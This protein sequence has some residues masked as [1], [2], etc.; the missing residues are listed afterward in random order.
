MCL[1]ERCVRNR[2]WPVRQKKTT[3]TIAAAT[4]T[5]PLLL[6]STGKTNTISSGMLS[7]CLDAPSRTV[8]CDT[9]KDPGPQFPH[10]WVRSWC[11]CKLECLSTIP[12]HWTHLFSADPCCSPRRQRVCSDWS[13]CRTGRTPVGRHMLPHINKH[14]LPQYLSSKY[15]T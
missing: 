13:P 11:Y 15:N 12:F 10:I 2:I 1:C 7:W 8:V 4:R 9:S 6:C 3:P 5:S 14:C